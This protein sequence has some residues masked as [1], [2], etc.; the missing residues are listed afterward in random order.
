MGYV[1][2]LDFRSDTLTRPTLAMRRAMAEAEVGDDVYGE[3]PTVNR[4]EA[5]LAETLG[6]ERALFF[7]SGTMA[8][9]TALLLLAPRASEVLAPEGAHVFEFEL[10]APAML[11]G[12]LVRSLP[13]PGGRPTPEALSKAVHTSVHQA[14]TALF[15]LE[16]THNLAGGT[17]VDEGRTKALLAA[18][19]AAGLRA[20]L[21]GARVWNAAVALN[22][23]PAALA[24]GFDSVMVSLSKGLGA[25]VGSAL[26]LPA[27]LYAEARRYR[28]VL[29]GGMR[30][31]GVLAAAAL[32]ALKDWEK[33]LAKDHALAQELAEG[34]T[35]LGL[36]VD[37][38]PE[39]NMV[40]LRVENAPAFS[41]RL[42]ALG[43]R[44]LPLGA[45]RVRF[46]THRD[47]PENA[48]EE[49]LARIARALEAG[50]V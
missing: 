37:P 42:A 21:D 50:P 29:G 19:R 44:A 38:W 43:V 17:V 49:A 22:T 25:P 11:A 1:E 10:A 33:T 46:V 31:A 13:A 27:A 7:P 36:S 45:D 6:F 48:A 5:V 34:L 30:Q 8:N 3:D 15:W 40:Y 41:Q 39:T 9:Q 35:K 2:S 32:V 14:P 4:L 16:N 24:H 18:A 47:L 28:K 23:A 12:V 26:L 20:H